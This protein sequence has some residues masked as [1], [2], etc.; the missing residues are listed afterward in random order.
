METRKFQY[1]RV[2][3]GRVSPFG[4]AVGVAA[5]V[6][7]TLPT[8]TAPHMSNFERAL[9]AEDLIVAMKAVD[10]MTQ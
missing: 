9:N 5:T 2:G 8:L 6:A 10:V 3:S 1:F 4:L 7:G